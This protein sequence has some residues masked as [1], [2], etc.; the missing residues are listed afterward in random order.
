MSTRVGLALRLVAAVMVLSLVAA[1]GDDDGADGPSSPETTAVDDTTTTTPADAGDEPA[2]SA[3][4]APSGSQG[5]LRGVSVEITSDSAGLDLAFAVTL[6]EVREAANPAMVW[7]ACSG[8]T[9]SSPG[10]VSGLYFV[11]AFDRFRDS[12]LRHV[13]IEA[14]DQVDGPGTYDGVVEVN[15]SAG[16]FVSVEGELTINADG[17]SGT[18]VGTD[19][20]GNDMT[21]TYRCEV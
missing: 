10:L 8:A 6:D 7:I 17:R 3:P 13:G 21:V 2:D 5:E 14:L 11:T 16:R 19:D 20:D 15:D 4:D 18:L 1:C 9:A 12:G